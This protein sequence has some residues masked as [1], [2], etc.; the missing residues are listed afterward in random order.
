MGQRN[1]SKDGQSAASVADVFL[2]PLRPPPEVRWGHFVPKRSPFVPLR[3][4]GIGAAPSDA[5]R[6]SSQNR[7]SSMQCAHVPWPCCSSTTV[8]V[9][10]GFGWWMEQLEFWGVVGKSGGGWPGAWRVGEEERRGGEE[11]G[12]AGQ[13]IYIKPRGLYLAAEEAGACQKH[14][15]TTLPNIFDNFGLIEWRGIPKFSG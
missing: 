14:P 11:G 1:I 3:A 8:A 10:L 12:G 5:G 13:T 9:A 4:S 6:K 15:K 2:F 7:R